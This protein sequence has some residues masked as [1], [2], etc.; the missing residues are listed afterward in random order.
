MKAKIPAHIFSGGYILRGTVKTRNAI[1]AVI[2]AGGLFF[3]LKLLLLFM[4]PLISLVIRLTVAFLVGGLCIIGINDQPVTIAITDYMN[5]KRTKGLAK[6]ALPMP[7]PE[8]K[9]KKRRKKK[10]KKE[11]EQ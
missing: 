10:E 3:I 8:K 6:M 7:I 4:N 1:E 11:E 9:E 5:F 2:I